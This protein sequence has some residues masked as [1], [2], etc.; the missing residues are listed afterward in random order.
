MRTVF[1]QVGY[2]APW[3]SLKNRSVRGLQ[4]RRPAPAHRPRLRVLPWF[5]ASKVGRAFVAR[6]PLLSPAISGRFGGWRAGRFLGHDHPTTAAAA[7]LPAFTTGGTGLVSRPLVCGT[8]LVRSAAALAG[9]FALLFGRHRSKSPAFLSLSA[10]RHCCAS[11]KWSA[12]PGHVGSLRSRFRRWVLN[13]RGARLVERRLRRLLPRSGS[14]FCG[15]LSVRS[16][17][18]LEPTDHG[19]IKDHA[20]G[21]VWPVRLSVVFFACYRWGLN[22]VP[23]AVA[24][25]CYRRAGSSSDWRQRR[26]A[27]VLLPAGRK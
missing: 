23:T 5:V 11:V 2:S 13:A 16:V 27:G 12:R 1:E 7:D 4:P 3:M 21:P 15:S 26:A 18:C 19:V 14:G 8:F 9:D 24:A 20:C 10:G 25:D 6:M 22:A 17:P